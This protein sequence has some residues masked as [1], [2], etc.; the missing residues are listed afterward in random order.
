MSEKPIRIVA[1]GGSVRPGNFTGKALALVADQ[2]ARSDDA[3]VDVVDLNEIQLPL[4]GLA[5]SDDMKALQERFATATGVLLA[6]PEYHGSFSSVIKLLIDNLGFP[7]VLSGKP[8][9]LLGVA[10][11]QIG[12]IKALEHLRSV[13][14]HVGAVVLPGPV[15]VAGVQKLFDEDGNCIDEST[16]KRIR[17]LATNLLD[18]IR[19]SICPRVALEEAVRR[20]EIEWMKRVAETD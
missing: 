4:P 11:G 14:S 6:T 18:Y 19:G 10:A 15:S 17:G 9:A 20:G 3:T 7:S 16:E 1:V 8:I 2:I 5:A 12:A 13:C